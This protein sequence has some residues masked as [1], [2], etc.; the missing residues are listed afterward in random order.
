MEIWRVLHWQEIHFMHNTDLSQA[1][2]LACEMGVLR[3]N[4]RALQGYLISVNQVR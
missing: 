3:E 2:M 1:L 4:W